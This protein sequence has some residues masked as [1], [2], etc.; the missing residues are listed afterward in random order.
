METTDPARALNTSLRVRVRRSFGG[1]LAAADMARVKS[2]QRLGISLRPYEVGD[3][4]RTMSRAHLLKTGELMTRTDFSPGR[5]NCGVIFHGYENQEFKGLESLANKGQVGLSVAALI[6]TFHEYLS[7]S[8]DFVCLEDKDLGKA[9]KLLSRR[10][11]SWDYTYVIS[12]FLFDSSSPTASA[13]AFYEGM[14]S[15]GFKR[16]AAFVVRDPL[17]AL[18]NNRLFDR[19]ASLIPYMMDS[20][21]DS[22]EEGADYLYSGREYGRHLKEQLD[23]FSSRAQKYGISTNV[24]DGRASVESVLAR[25]VNQ[26]CLVGTTRLHRN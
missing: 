15:M 23:D 9:L 12:D 4:M 21:N 16:G 17:E 6:Q 14:V 20:P 26:A 13:D 1:I 24:F 7:H 3:P 2:P 10:S 19:S 22:L 5:Q 8:F 25:I 18:W 11:S